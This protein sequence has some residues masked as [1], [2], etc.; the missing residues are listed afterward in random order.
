MSVIERKEKH[1]QMLICILDYRATV[2]RCIYKRDTYTGSSYTLLPL[3]HPALF[4][5]LKRR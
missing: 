3:N 4:P 1:L 2:L 5:D